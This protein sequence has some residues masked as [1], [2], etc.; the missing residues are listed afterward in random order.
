VRKEP[1]VTGAETRYGEQDA[2]V[3]AE[4]VRNF[5]RAV[6]RQ[7]AV[8]DFIREHFF[9][10]DEPPAGIGNALRL[11]MVEALGTTTTEDWDQVASY[12]LAYAR[13][14]MEDDGPAVGF[15]PAAPVLEGWAPPPRLLRAWALRARRKPLVSVTPSEIFSWLTERGSATTR[16]IGQHFNVS[17]SSVRLHADAL[18]QQGK[19]DVAPGGRH[20]P[21]IYSVRRPTE[22]PPADSLGGELPAAPRRAHRIDLPFRRDRARRVHHSPINP[23]PRSTQMTDAETEELEAEIAVGEK[24]GDELWRIKE[25]ETGNVLR[26]AITS[27][28]EYLWLLD[29]LN[30]G[31]DYANEQQARRDAEASA[32]A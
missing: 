7:P 2:Q 15:P 13:D 10:G 14:C 20:R 28:R 1:A 19:V 27:E 17:D 5:T 24:Y 21:R 30:H 9:D 25:V 4:L 29:T 3:L 26:D 32:G 31:D 12:L 18:V 23:E 8:A 16:E 6:L 22:P 11:A